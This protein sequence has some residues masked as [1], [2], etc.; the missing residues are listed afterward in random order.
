[1]CSEGLQFIL[2]WFPPRSFSFLL[3][4]HSWCLKIKGKFE[5]RK[6]ELLCQ[7][8]PLHIKSVVPLLGV[9][10][11]VNAAPPQGSAVWTLLRR[12]AL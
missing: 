4:S 5:N 8:S 12:R 2:N 6:V 9:G 7:L 10:S 3:G 11:D 1:M